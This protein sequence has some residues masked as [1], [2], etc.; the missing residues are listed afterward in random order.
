[1]KFVNEPMDIGVNIPTEGDCD[2]DCRCN[3][4][5]CIADCRCNPNFCIAN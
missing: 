3:P 2:S 1:M 4:N 5:F